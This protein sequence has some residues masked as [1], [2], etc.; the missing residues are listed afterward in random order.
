MTAKIEAPKESA[1]TK[2]L[3]LHDLT[4][5]EVAES[6]KP[7]ADR[8]G[9]LVAGPDRQG[10]NAVIP[11]KLWR[12]WQ[13]DVQAAGTVPA[14]VQDYF[15]RTKHLTMPP[16]GGLQIEVYGSNPA[17]RPIKE[18]QVEDIFGELNLV[19][20]ICDL[21]TVLVGI[22]TMPTAPTKKKNSNPPRFATSFTGMEGFCNCPR[23]WA[24]EKYWKTVPY[25]QSPEAKWGDRGHKTAENYLLNN[26]HTGNLPTEPEFLP[27]VQKYC[28]SFL[29]SGA[30]ILA[31][32]EICCTKDLQPC[33][34]KD[35]N[36]V[37]FRFK[38]DVFL[39]KERKLTYADW[40]FGKP[41]TTPFSNPDCPSQIE[42]AA[43][44]ASIH[45][46]DSW[47]IF[48]GRL[49]YVKESDPK[50]AM[51]GLPAPIRREDVPSIWE[52]IFAV[53]TRMEQAW[54]NEVFQARSSGLCKKYCGDLSCPHNGRR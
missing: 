54:E 28:D 4:F 22:A 49:I 36:T 33:G 32:Q 30:K 6:K 11:E 40:K 39:L 10:A 31:E 13:R 42:V 53:T 26:L 45:M 37:W 12:M 29:R 25:E 34:W 19:P 46:P 2:C 18:E 21:E 51:V 7:V 1:G 15:E 52:R 27:Y 35:W 48:D 44:L 17:L 50:K 23:S 41:K 47:D 9:Y 16:K 3:A 20:Q 43:A 8:C 14:A 38:G 5:P 24:A